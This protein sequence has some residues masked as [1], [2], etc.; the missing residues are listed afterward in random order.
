M[1]GEMGRVLDGLTVTVTLAPSEATLMPHARDK[2]RAVAQQTW[3]VI[4]RDRIDVPLRSWMFL[5]N[6]PKDTGRG[7]PALV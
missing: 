7:P 4:L 2:K 6:A 1:Y 3:N 5:Y